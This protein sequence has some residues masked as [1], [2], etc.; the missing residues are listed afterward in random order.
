MKFRRESWTVFLLLSSTVLAAAQVQVPSTNYVII[1]PNQ[2]LVMERQ[3]QLEWSAR[4]FETLM[5]VRP[6]RGR[7]ILTDAPDGSVINAS[8]ESSA[9]INTV[10]LVPQPPAADGT[11]WSLSWFINERAGSGARKPNATVL[12]HEAAHLQL[13]F[14]VNFHASPALKGRFN[15]YGSFLPDWLDEAIAVYHEPDALKASRRE[16]FNFRSRIPLR[17]FFTMDHPGT[18]GRVEVLEIEAK[19]PEEA[20]RKIAAFKASQHASLQA[21]AE[22]LAKDRA[23][24]D[25]FYTQCLA[26]IEY[27]TARG[28]LPFFRFLLVEQNYGKSIDEVLQ[29]WPAKVNEIAEQRSAVEKA[30]ARQKPPPRVVA[31][32]DPAGP[33]PD[34]ATKVAGVLVRPGEAVNGM[35]S[36]ID[37]LEADFERWVQTNYPRYRPNLPRFPGS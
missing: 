27:L 28:G 23:S 7:I 13:V 2:A 33:L 16:R 29:S 6:P 12:T 4:V 14:T 15:G 37:F 32:G 9:L 19:T 26:V 3:A 22:S 36:S 30:A 34:W 10:P 24:V 20:G 18:T 35:P 21:T 17:T 25:E 31:P 5:G 1:A 11:L 8:G